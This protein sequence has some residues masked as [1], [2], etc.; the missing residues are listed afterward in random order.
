MNNTLYYIVN[1]VFYPPK[2]PQGDDLDIIKEHDLCALVHQ[3][4][5]EYQQALSSDQ[6]PRWDPITRMLANL[7]DSHQ[8]DHLSKET[9]KRSMAAMGPGGRKFISNHLL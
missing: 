1:H 9:V 3:Y 5:C 6:K 4:A 8:S 2:L 7:R